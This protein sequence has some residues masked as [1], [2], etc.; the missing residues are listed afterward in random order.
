MLIDSVKH[1][2]ALIRCVPAG[3]QAPHLLI[4]TLF[5][6]SGTISILLKTGTAYSALTS[7][8]TTDE[9]PKH[10]RVVSVMRKAACHRFY[11]GNCIL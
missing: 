2:F 4:C 11:Y 7:I 5:V 9:L 10:L 6:L 1:I 8:P 3:G